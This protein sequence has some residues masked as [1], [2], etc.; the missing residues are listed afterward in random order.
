MSDNNTTNESKGQS[1]EEIEKRVNELAEAKVKAIREKEEFEREKQELAREKAELAKW[2]EE[3]TR[4]T[5][6]AGTPQPQ[7]EPQK[8]PANTKEA[9][10]GLTKE[11]QVKLY[12]DFQRRQ[13]ESKLANFKNQIKQHIVDNKDSYSNLSKVDENQSFSLIVNKMNSHKEVTGQDLSLSDAVKAVETDV[14]S[15]VSTLMPK[16]SPES[17]D[18]GD[19]LANDGYRED[20]ER[21]SITPPVMSQELEDKSSTN[22]TGT[23]GETDYSKIPQGADLAKSIFQKVSD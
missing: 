22:E 13:Y 6:E 14:K 20:F 11:Q 12:E 18:T 5:R 4:K 8:Q 2:K 3:L 10:D 16:K 17:L 7:P 19:E 1:K 21:N 15:L 9:F 23:S